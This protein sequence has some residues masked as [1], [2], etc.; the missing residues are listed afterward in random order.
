M[1]TSRPVFFNRGFTIADLSAL[2]KYPE[3]RHWLVIS[4]INGTTAENISKR[5]LVVIGPCLDE[6]FLDFLMISVTSLSDTGANQ[7]KDVSGRGRRSDTGEQDIGQMLLS[8][9]S[10]SSRSFAFFCI[11]KSLKVLASAAFDV[12]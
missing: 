1:S 3:E 5:S 6:V 2:G 9:F 8:I 10:R 7:D 11:K 12:A 4:V